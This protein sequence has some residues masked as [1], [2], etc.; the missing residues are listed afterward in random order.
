VVA[1]YAGDLKGNVYRVEMTGSNAPVE[2]FNKAPLFRAVGSTG[3]PQPIVVA[4][5]IFPSPNGGNMVLFGTGRLIDSVDSQDQSQQTFYGVWDKTTTGSSAETAVS[6][7]AANM[8]L[9]TQRQQLVQQSITPSVSPPGFFAVSSNPVDFVAK[10]GWFMDLDIISATQRVIYPSALV[11]EFVLINT[12]QPAL[13]SKDPCLQTSGSSAYFLLPALDGSAYTAAPVWDVSGNGEVDQSTTG[14]TDT[15]TTAT[16][17]TQAAGY[18]TTQGAGMTSIVLLPSA[19]AAAGDTP[20]DNV[21]PG[22][23]RIG[24][25]H[26]LGAKCGPGKITQRVWQQLMTPPF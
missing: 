20:F 15:I 1:V 25:A 24:D 23:N 19:V 9:G 13:L 21:G 14:N 17:T 3:A 26:C 2:S 4:P 5:T 7:F 22:G 11:G 12:V 6:P 16:G 10:I 18:N 8:A